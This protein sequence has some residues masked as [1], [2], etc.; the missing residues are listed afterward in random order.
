MSWCTTCLDS[1]KLREPLILDPLAL[2]SPSTLLVVAFLALLRLLLSVCFA[3]IL[4][5]VELSV[6][7]DLVVSWADRIFAGRSV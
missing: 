5:A 7:Q 1:L 4:L 6:S 3:L 2:F